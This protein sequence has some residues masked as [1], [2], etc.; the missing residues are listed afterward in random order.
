MAARFADPRRSLF[1]W[2]PDDITTAWY[3]ELS[4]WDP[5]LP[6]H[7]WDSQGGLITLAGD[8]AHPMTFQRV[9]GLNHALTD[10][11]KLCKVIVD[12][13][14]SSEGFPSGRA[15]AIEGHEKEMMA[16]TSEEVRL[17]ELNSKMLQQVQQSQ[18]FGK[19]LRK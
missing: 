9:Q 14:Y 15:A 4:H 5:A 3:A 7:K 10:S 1:E 6:E 19:G 11:V 17:G 12:C 18:V 8:A 16:R 2:V 13:W